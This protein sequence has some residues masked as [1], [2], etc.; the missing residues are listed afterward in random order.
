M[1][2]LVYTGPEG[3]PLPS[4]VSRSITSLRSVLYPNYTVQAVTQQSLVSAPWS[5]T[6][7]LLVFPACR[8][9]LT[10]GPSLS[11]AIKAYI[12][13]GGALLGIRAGVKVG[14]SSFETP[15]HT[16]RVQEHNSGSTLYCKLAPGPDDPFTRVA[17]ESAEEVVVPGI[18]ESGEVNFEG[19]EKVPGARVLARRA[20][21]KRVVAAAFDVGLGRVG[22]WGVHIEA[23]VTSQD[24]TSDVR[25][26][27]EGRKALFRATLS[28]AG[29]QVPAVA[30]AAALQPLPQLLVSA[31][32]RPT[33]T[34]DVL[35]SLEVVPPGTFE[36]A[37]DTF[38]FHVAS[39]AE[40]LL[41]KCR[42][43]ESVEQPRH[44][45]VYDNGDLPSPTLT[46]MFDL[47]QYFIHLEA[48]RKSSTTA[49]GEPWGI[50]ETMLYGEVVTSTQ[51]LLDKYVH[52]HTILPALDDS[53][54]TTGICVS[55]LNYPLLCSHLRPTRSLGAGEVVI[56][57][58]RPPA[59]CSS[60]C[61]S[62]SRS[63]QY[64][65]HNWCSFNI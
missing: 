12:E 57:G 23:P 61:G 33:A 40:E 22:L 49:I 37:T 30:G 17:V 14:G 62:A 58:S 60:L 43:S 54:Y 39:D 20:D 7:A 31:P 59:A 26:A 38:A 55:S 9:P 44:I 46:P 5:P 64:P 1:N 15:E 19:L 32:S 2:V 28:A 25:D 10:F 45:I 42:Q 6:C 27:E 24:G 35:R 48:A 50:G 16:F 47:R 56:L 36:D 52:I 41:Q 4:S 65:Q 51:T 29:L 34:S 21:D 11:S 3:R 18:V 63:P 8:D 13:N 53:L